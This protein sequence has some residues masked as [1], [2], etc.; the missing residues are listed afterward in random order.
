MA[1][2]MTV[3]ELLHLWLVAQSALLDARRG[4]HV[5]RFAYLSRLDEA[6]RAAK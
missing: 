6:G 1:L 3:Q 4:E 2:A 5:A